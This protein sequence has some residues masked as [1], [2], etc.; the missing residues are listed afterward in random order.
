MVTSFQW[1]TILV[2]DMIQ[3]WIFKTL[4]L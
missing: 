3:L 1:M 4:A 2:E